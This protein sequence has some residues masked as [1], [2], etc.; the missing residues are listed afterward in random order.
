[1]ASLECALLGSLILV[2]MSGPPACYVE[3]CDIGFHADETGECEPN[4]ATD[5]AV[6]AK[7]LDRATLY[8][9]PY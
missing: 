8:V 7:V 1:M 2:A 6:P 4:A 9:V 3:P 5:T